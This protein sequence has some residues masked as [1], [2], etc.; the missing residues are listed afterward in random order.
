MARFSDTHFV[1]KKCTNP[2]SK[3]FGVHKT[4]TELC[5]TLNV[6][7]IVSLQTF[8][9]E[10]YRVNTLQSEQKNARFSALYWIRRRIF[11]NT[12][13]VPKFKISLMKKCGF[14]RIIH[15]DRRPQFTVP[16]ARQMCLETG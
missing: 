8:F 6:W 4:C 11:W 5:R 16:S 14:A 1:P 15:S 12:M 7:I 9:L 13:A 10:L 2:Q 3:R